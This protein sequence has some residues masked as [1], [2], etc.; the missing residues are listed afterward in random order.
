MAINSSI[1]VLDET[2]NLYASGYQHGNGELTY[3]ELMESA[4]ATNKD[5]DGEN[6]KIITPTEFLAEWHDLALKNWDSPSSFTVEAIKNLSEIAESDEFHYEVQMD[7]GFIDS[8]TAYEK[9]VQVFEV[10]FT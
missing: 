7:R 1:I 6:T 5:W 2:R 3:H 8:I 4:M 10:L 9:G